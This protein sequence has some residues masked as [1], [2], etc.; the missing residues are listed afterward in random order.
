MTWGWSARSRPRRAR[1]RSIESPRPPPLSQST[2]RWLEIVQD[3]VQSVPARDHSRQSRQGRIHR[4]AASQRRL[5]GRIPD[6]LA[7]GEA[8][9]D[10]VG[11]C[12]GRWIKTD[13]RSSGF[14]R[15]RRFI[16]IQ[17][18]SGTIGD[19]E[20]RPR[21]C[22]PAWP[23]FGDDEHRQAAVE[24]VALAL[25][26]PRVVTRVKAATKGLEP[27]AVPLGGIAIDMTRPH[28][29]VQEEGCAQRVDLAQVSASS[30]AA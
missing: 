10:G 27:S 1:R 12:D 5:A 6:R 20:S 14:P 9:D 26:R 19:L 17:L 24:P 28:G 18:D 22:H 4:R 2:Q 29:V 11:E 30:H 21:P 16:P 8:A 15:Q 7:R 25:D 23:G 13:R 3:E